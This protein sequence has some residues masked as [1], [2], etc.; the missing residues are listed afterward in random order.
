MCLLE[1]QLKK[2]YTNIHLPLFL[3]KSTAVATK[4]SELLIYIIMHLPLLFDVVC[5]VHI[6]HLFTQYI[7]YPCTKCAVCSVP[8]TELQNI[9]YCL[10]CGYC[11]PTIYGTYNR[12]FL[13]SITLPFFVLVS[14]SINELYEHASSHCSLLWYEKDFVYQ[15][16][17][18]V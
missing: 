4:F 12:F 3:L 2:L 13:H 15:Q 10:W 1:T 5:L 14:L 7:L 16:I 8:F 17:I 6:K 9:L 11:L 18:T